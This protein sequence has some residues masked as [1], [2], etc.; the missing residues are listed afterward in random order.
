[1]QIQYF[2]GY[3]SPAFTVLLRPE[4]LNVNL[5]F[6]KCKLTITHCRTCM[7]YGLKRVQI[8]CILLHLTSLSMYCGARIAG[9]NIM[10]S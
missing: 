3:V 8:Q 6:H 7:M 9:C 5:L 4:N 10:T 1:M 2:V